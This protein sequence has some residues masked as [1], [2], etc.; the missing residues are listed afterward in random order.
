LI[1]FGITTTAPEYLTTL[2]SFLKFYISIILIWRFNPFRKNEMTDFDRRLV[3]SCAMFLLTTTTITSLVINYIKKK[4][5][6]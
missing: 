1:L 2:Q 3:F 5:K 4:Y 6:S